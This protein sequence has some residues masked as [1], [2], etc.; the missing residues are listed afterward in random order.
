M[1]HGMVVN[2]LFLRYNVDYTSILSRSL[3]S[4]LMDV[5]SY[6]SEDREMTSR[7]NS[8]RVNSNKGSPIIF[9]F[10]PQCN[11]HVLDISN[12]IIENNDKSANTNIPGKR[13]RTAL[14]MLRGRRG[15]E[16]PLSKT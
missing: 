4:L 11:G 3:E 14:S 16:P 10:K 7:Q 1:Y 6:F 12:K 13:N 2:N 15:Y 9:F 8:M 5:I